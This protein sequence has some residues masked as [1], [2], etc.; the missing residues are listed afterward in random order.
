MEESG[1]KLEHSTTIELRRYIF[2]GNWDLAVKTLNKM[3]DLMKDKT[4]L[5]VSFFH[6][7]IYILIL[8]I[9]LI[10]SLTLSIKQNVFDNFPINLLYFMDSL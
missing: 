7:K 10:I 5:Q 8:I 6:E 1:C 9:L 3:K 4:N 2:E